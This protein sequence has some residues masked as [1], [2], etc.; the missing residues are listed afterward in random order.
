[1]ESC[2]PWKLE[3][4]G[5]PHFE[6]GRE[7]VVVKDQKVKPM[8]VDE[9]VQQNEQKPLL[10]GKDHDKE[11]VIKKEEIKTDTNE[12]EKDA[13]EALSKL[14]KEI[15][16]TPKL[17][18]KLDVKFMPKV[19]PNGEKLNMFNHT[20]NLNMTLN[21]V[22]LNGAV[23]ITPKDPSFINNNGLS[24]GMGEK[25]WFSILPLGNP[26]DHQSKHMDSKDGYIDTIT[27]Q[28]NHFI[29]IAQINIF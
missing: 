3:N 21:P 27:P 26:V 15:L 20:S 8:E 14:G 2:E 6:D 7:Q 29:Y 11:N 28:V 5:M 12:Q 25:P 13:I 22:I 16:I 1:M 10:N 4:Q 23:T 17:E 19:T 9:L 24:N 18:T